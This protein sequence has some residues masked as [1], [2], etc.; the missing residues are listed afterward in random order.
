[1]TVSDLVALLDARGLKPQKNTSGWAA[2]CPAHEDR[3]P[4]LSVSE[5][6]DGR[7]LLNC[8]AGCDF[9]S[10]VGAL[11]IKDADLFPEKPRVNGGP[12]RI[13]ATYPYHDAAGAL[14]FEVVRMEP[15]DFRQRRPDPQSVDGWAWNMRG[16]E[17]VPY[18]LPQ[19]MQAVERGDAVFVVE[20]ERDVETLEHQGFCA[21]TSPGG[22]GK[23]LDSF[24][25]YFAGAHVV[26][27]PDA[28][29]PGR[30]HGQKV[31]AALRP[32]AASVKVVEVPHGKDASDYFAAGGTKAELIALAEE[33]PEWTPPPER[34]PSVQ[35][36]PVDSSAEIRGEIIEVLNEKGLTA[37][38]RRTRIAA[39]VVAALA[40]RGR[41]Y[42]HAERR[43]FES[44]CFFD[45][46]TKRLERV[47]SDA[48][49]AWLSGWVAVNRSDSLFN[50]IRSGVETAAVAGELTT[51]ILP[52]AFWAARP[53]IV[54]LSNGPGAVVRISADGVRLEDNGIDGVLFPASKT[55]EPWTLTEARDPFAACSI[56]RDVQ[57]TAA[58][59]LDLLRLWAYSL[60][61]NPRSKPPLCA[62]GPVGSGKTR[63]IK[64]I[65]E[66]YG[67]PFQAL[68]VE[69][70]REGD[71]WPNLDGGGLVCL[72]NA[73]TRT[74]WLPD[75]LANA[76]TDGCSMRRRL[77]TDADTVTLRARGWVA[78]TSANP[79]FASDPGL[80]DRLMVVRMGRREG[81]TSDARLSEEI[82]AA[83]DAGLS[84]IA[85]TLSTA[86]ADSNPTPARLNA[87]HPDFAAFGVRIGRALG[88]EA[89]AIKALSAAEADKSR[90]CLE[91]DPVGL[92]L[93]S[94]IEAHGSFTGTAAELLPR[95]VAMDGELEG[96]LSAK[97]LGKRLVTLW[98]HVAALFPGSSHGKDRDKVTR[99]TIKPPCAGFAGFQTAF[100][101]NSPAKDSQGDFYQNTDSNPANPAEPPGE[102][103][104]ALSDTTNPYPD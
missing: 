53:G 92:A 26:V 29:K 94:T 40:R 68:K 38:E 7:V 72:D 54:Y 67:L 49:L 39:A 96:K 45:G 71:F 30:E 87:R 5:G 41:F 52:E 35:A 57:A 28:D 21:T 59:G 12:R 33:A 77:Y 48:F 69:E 18:R 34:V 63:L 95:L 23:W 60:P 80:A 20:G 104:L 78:V 89:D 4:S 55:L 81:E 31:A 101:E 2:K 66:L 36:S 11:G 62:C 84:H 91:N 74:K 64:G 15:K 86:L 79:L 3:N 51:G 98:P 25:A 47:Q 8:H 56:F 27:I 24:N 1:V 22:A 58:H 100:P 9:R 50:F 13:A 76:A 85:E 83:R 44:A 102:L 103:D 17:R 6:T 14:V 61:T 19:L 16:V 73:D 65:A 99:F 70:D 43:D 42:H 97:R 75:A 37:T 88:R 46:I 10:I 82:Q 93:A 90:F 32:V